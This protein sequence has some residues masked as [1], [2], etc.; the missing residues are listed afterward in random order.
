[1]GQDGSVA[2]AIATAAREVLAIKEQVNID[3]ESKPCNPVNLPNW[4][5]E[6]MSGHH[7]WLPDLIYV[8][9]RFESDR[10]IVCD[11]AGNI[12]RDNREM[13]PK[14]CPLERSRV[15]PGLV[16]AHSHAFQRVDSRAH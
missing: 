1:M 16:N 6:F 15:L 2:R 12:V 4:E 9:G 5:T 11:D 10:A 14:R 3:T 8:N 7:A 13:S